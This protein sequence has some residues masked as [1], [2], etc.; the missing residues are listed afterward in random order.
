[1]VVDRK[2]LIRIRTHCMNL[3]SQE[4]A[5]QSLDFS[6]SIIEVSP[7]WLKLTGYERDEVIG[8]HFME[9]L[10]GKSLLKVNEHFPSL[11]DYGYVNN[12]QLKI[13][14][15]D[16]SVI[17]VRLTGTSKYNEEGK[18]ERTFCEIT[19]EAPE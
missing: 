17:S 7:G 1:M 2:K 5:V 16:K 19:P 18:F 6:G 13:R 9:F 8:R 10:C 3:K 15:K 4:I 14:G 11:K 12:V